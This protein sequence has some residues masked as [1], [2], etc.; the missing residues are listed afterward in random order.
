VFDTP[1]GLPL[2]SVN[3]VNGQAKQG[4]V[5]DRSILS[6]ALSTQLEYKYLAYLTGRKQYY[7]TVEKVMNM[8]YTADFSRSKNLLPAMYS[9]Q[10]GLPNSSMSPRL[11]LVNVV[12]DG[13]HRY[14]LRWSVCG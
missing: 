6:E 11:G 10:T 9:I 5:G 1:S 2:Y 8:M 4:W 12:A 13:V 7:T 14:T 3:P